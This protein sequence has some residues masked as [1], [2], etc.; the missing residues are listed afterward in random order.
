MDLT[1]FPSFDWTEYYGNV[2]EAIPPNMPPPLGKDVDLRMMVDSDHAGDKRTRHSRTGFI[3]FCNSAPII[4]LSKQQ[5]TNETSVFGAEFVAMMHGIKTLRGLRY[6]I[7]MM[8]VPL[9]ETTYIYG[10][11]KS[12]VTNSFRPELIL[13]KKCNSI[14]Y[15]AICESVAMGETLLTH[16]RTGD[17]LVDFLTKTT[18]GTKCRK[19]VSGVVYDIY[20][21]FQNSRL[22]RSSH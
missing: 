12:Q 13:K 2:E 11:N 8:G 7:L 10:D 15:H 18:S 22:T 5:A 19:L 20:D 4:W 3:I 16:I 9:S 14:C 1:A 6:K 21:D 17:N